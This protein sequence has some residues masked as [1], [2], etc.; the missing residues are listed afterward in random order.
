MSRFTLAHTHWA[1]AL[2]HI[3]SMSLSHTRSV[4]VISGRFLRSWVVK[5]ILC[6]VR[7]FGRLG[8]VGVAWTLTAVAVLWCGRVAVAWAVMRVDNG[9]ILG[10]KK[11][12]RLGG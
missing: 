5:C 6:D 7:Q 8:I 11:S 12:H 3:R 4:G 10:Y 2:T 9:V 1:V